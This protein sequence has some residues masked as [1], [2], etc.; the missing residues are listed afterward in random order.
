MKGAT[1][2]KFNMRFLEFWA[3]GI[4]ISFFF[5][6]L[7]PPFLIKLSIT[8]LYLKFHCF[9]AVFGKT[10]LLSLSYV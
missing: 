1:L 2:V 4:I 6:Y 3:W 10:E 9:L 7:L 8:N 5:S